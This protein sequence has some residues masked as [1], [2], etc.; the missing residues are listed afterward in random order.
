MD[1]IVG[2]LGLE[3]Q[4]V[5]AQQRREHV[6]L[7]SGEYLGRAKDRRAYRF[8]LEADLTAVDGSPARLRHN[9]RWY[10]V[11]VVGTSGRAVVLNVPDQLQGSLAT[12]L[13]QTDA[14]FLLQLLI[15]RWRAVEDDGTFNWSLVTACLESADLSERFPGKSPPNAHQFQ[16]NERQASLIGTVFSTT[17]TYLWG[18]PGTG[19]TTSVA[20][21]VYELVQAG[22]SVLLVSNTNAALD[23]AVGRVVESVGLEA[24][25]VVRIG[26]GPDSGL[27]GRTPPILLHELIAER[28]SSLASLRK[29]A[30]ALLA[31]G[32]RRLKSLRR[33][34]EACDKELRDLK[35]LKADQADGLAAVPVNAKRL[36][37]ASALTERLRV[38]LARQ[39]REAAAGVGKVSSALRRDVL[40]S[41]RDEVKL[42]EAV[43]QSRRRCE[44]LTKAYQDSLTLGLLAVNASRTRACEDEIA[45]E[46]LQVATHQ[47][48][49]DVLDAALKTLHSEIVH[50]ADVVAA[51]AYKA[52]IDEAVRTRE[53]DVV[54]VDEA[55]MLP[56][57]LCLLVTGLATRSVVFAGD[58]RQLSPIAVSPD[59]EAALWLRRDA[60]KAAN[61]P[62]LITTRAR[63][64]ALVTLQ[65]QHRMRPQ[66]ADV[67]SAVSYPE[68]PLTTST[69]VRGRQPR[70]PA[71]LADSPLVLV[72]TSSLGSRIARE[73]GRASRYNVAHAQLIA[74]LADV[75]WSEESGDVGI[76]APYRVQ[77]K[78]LSTIR[79]SAQTST[80]HRFQGGER[81]TI[82]LDTTVAGG[83][84]IGQWFA[85]QRS[86]E[87]GARLLNV[88]I[89][90]ARER[91]VVVADMNRLLRDAPASG[92]VRQF[93]RL[94]RTF[95][96]L[97]L[98]RLTVGGQL[99][100]GGSLDALINDVRRSQHQAL[101]CSRILSRRAV[102]ALVASSHPEDT[103]VVT[104]PP[105]QPV[106]ADRERHALRIAELEAGGIRVELRD[107][108]SEDW[109]V[110]DGRITWTR[111]GGV[112]SAGDEKQWGL[113]R[114]DPDLAGQLLLVQARKRLPW[115]PPAMPGR[116][117]S[118]CPTCSRPRA[119]IER[120]D[121]RVWDACTDSACRP[122]EDRSRERSIPFQR[123]ERTQRREELRR[124]AVHDF[125][126]DD[127]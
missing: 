78:L 42:A 93:L 33:E 55:S 54:I 22:S 46:Q 127:K 49:V 43:E 71:F 21:L 90:R 84:S 18:P 31:E 25:S 8:Q 82:L 4:A 58:F 111:S 87:D 50:A 120:F 11:E 1:D 41:E 114:E 47:R 121:G 117:T 28:G 124:V 103:T 13:L 3:M 110:I 5:R 106:P 59:E 27:G 95:E 80:V 35:Q 52:C 39:E 89:S 45:S 96:Q 65:E 79:Q 86:E 16:L 61:I 10:D 36:A 48:E 105:T 113:R 23:T 109:A 68:A 62:E 102:S 40:M 30:S 126:V 91:L 99:I 77:A 115:D 19:K 122:M 14:S 104:R 32:R 76:I 60:F 107:P 63:P 83:G 112:L 38:Q 53:Y 20:A 72:D 101:I 17:R 81:D 92:P 73:A 29:Q 12:G 67:V 85:A 66:I 116:W 70:Q 44:K 123:D 57:S 88:A 97:P 15:D 24:H 108:C 37:S 69:S 26:G 119:R 6:G 74:A 125:L 9:D 118:A 98:A 34:R 2:A 75:A 56:L 100:S 64:Q 94:C 7:T 51:T